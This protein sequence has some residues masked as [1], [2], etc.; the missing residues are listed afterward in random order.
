MAHAP[1]EQCSEYYAIGEYSI[2]TMSLN[3]VSNLQKQF[4]KHMISVV[5]QASHWPSII[6]RCSTAHWCSWL[7]RCPLKAE[8]TGSSP[9]CA[10]IYFSKDSKLLLLEPIICRSGNLLVPIA[11]GNLLV[12]FLEK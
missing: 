2:Q 5:C 11:T 9:V 10:T 1:G 3:N 12:P 6:N 7:T 8:I 4:R